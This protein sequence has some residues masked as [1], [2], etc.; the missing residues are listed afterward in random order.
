MFAL[1]GAQQSFVGENANNGLGERWGD[2]N[3][4][5]EGF[6]AWDARFTASMALLLAVKFKFKN[7]IFIINKSDQK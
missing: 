2:L 3:A 1:G 4:R 6:Q 7:K 5:V